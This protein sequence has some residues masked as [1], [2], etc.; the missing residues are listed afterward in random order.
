MKKIFLVFIV[1]LSFLD[2]SYGQSEAIWMR[3]PA[4][5]P[6]GNSIV[7]SYKGDLWK[8]PTEGGLATP[9]TLHEGHDF[10]PVW[11]NDG[12]QI[13][14]ASQ[15]YG[16]FDVYI[17]PSSGGKADRLTYHS[18]GDYPSSFAPDNKSVLFYFK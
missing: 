11:S 2:F 9:M 5:S 17:M 12:K 8:I 1:F 18:S 16:N 13:A 7:F 15:R 6:D 10:Q 3:Y 14:F 4:I